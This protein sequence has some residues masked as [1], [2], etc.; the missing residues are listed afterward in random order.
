MLQFT[1]C[2]QG[3]IWLVDIG[4]CKRFDIFQLWGIIAVI[5]NGIIVIIFVT[6]IVIIIVFLIIL[7]SI[8][9]LPLGRSGHW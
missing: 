1:R 3:K 5:F 8:T 6:L 2:S 4:P 9:I 7:I